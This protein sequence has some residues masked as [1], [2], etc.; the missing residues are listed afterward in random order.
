VPRRVSLPGAEEL[1]R[2]TGQASETAEP[3]TGN[4]EPRHASVPRPRRSSGR[5]KHDEKMTV[6]VT[7]DELLDLEHARLRLRREFGVGVDRGRVVR[8]AIAMALAD[9]ETRGA[10]SELVRRLRGS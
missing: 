10:E 7:A 9:M 4:R 3:S 2:P 1:F 5:V 8:E 6:Y